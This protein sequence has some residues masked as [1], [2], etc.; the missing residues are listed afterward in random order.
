MFHFKDI[1]QILEDK[2]KKITELS[3]RNES[4]DREMENLYKEL[5]VT[6]EQLSS[7]IQKEE[8]FT[9][10]NWKEMQKE[11]EKLDQ[12]LQTEIKSIRNPKEAKKAYSQRK[13]N[14]QWL[15]V[16]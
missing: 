8:N 2:N 14:P 7:F 4:L 1:E 3:I 5:K 6:P 12:K 9:E 15:F 10:K 13:I 11:K 16:K